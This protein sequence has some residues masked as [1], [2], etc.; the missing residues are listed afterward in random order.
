MPDTPFDEAAAESA[1]APTE[2]P[3]DWE[4]PALYWEQRCQQAWDE[5]D[6][7]ARKLNELQQRYASAEAVANRTH[8]RA[9]DAEQRL[10]LAREQGWRAEWNGR[11]RVIVDEI[12]V[13][14]DE[15]G[16]PWPVVTI[17]GLR[18]PW[19]FRSISVGDIT[20]NLA[21]VTLVLE[22]GLIVQSNEQPL[23]V[24]DELVR[25]RAETLIERSHRTA[26]TFSTEPAN[27]AEAEAQ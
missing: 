1:S 5:R 27:T 6:N 14:R 15:P 21:T 22:A 3:P 17:D 25:D 19:F 10:H 8:Q 16:S 4:R 26:A 9:Q 18:L 7:L 24:S 20:D 23:Q 13:E 11:E 2:T 12:L